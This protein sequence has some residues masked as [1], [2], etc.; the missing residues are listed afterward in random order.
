MK[1]DLKVDIFPRILIF[2]LYLVNIVDSDHE[3]N[4]EVVPNNTKRKDLTSIERREIVYEL[5][6]GAKIHGEDEKLPKGRFTEVAKK[7]KIIWLV[8]VCTQNDPKDTV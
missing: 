2:S 3:V 1:I 5:L 7:F 8:L 6:E 4:G